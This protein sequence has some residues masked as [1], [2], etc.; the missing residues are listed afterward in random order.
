MEELFTENE[1]FLRYIVVGDV[2]TLRRFYS[3]IKTFVLAEGP[4]DGILGF[5]EGGGLA[6][7][8]IIEQFRNPN[9]VFTF[10]CGV[11]FS[12]MWPID[13]HEFQRSD[14]RNMD[15]ISDGDLINI[16]TAHIW[17]PKDDLHPV[18]G[19]KARELC[20]SSLVEEFKHGLGHE[21]PGTAST[22]GV[23]ESVRAISRTIE[24]ADEA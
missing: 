1:E 14:L 12:A 22:V 18:V 15:P 8:M 2:S 3:N 9:S 21:I 5:S 7:S 24:K 19:S 20:E 17:D 11:F 13:L 16:P 6:A 4:F 10:R 23:F